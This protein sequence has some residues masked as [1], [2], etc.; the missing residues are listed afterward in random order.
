MTLKLGVNRLG[1]S[2][3]NDFQIEH[4]T[5]SSRHCEI[6]V[7]E[8]AILVRDCGSTNGTYVC[9]ERVTE[10]RLAAG[11]EFSVGDVEIFV[12]TTDVTI[13]VPKIEVT[14]PAPPVVLRDGSLECPRHPDAQ[15]THQCT[16]C[17][18]V[19]CEACVHRLR[20]RGGK[21]LELCPICS[22]RCEPIGPRKK[23]KKSLIGF[24]RKTV[25]M[26]LNRNSKEP[27]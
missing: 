26:K 18:E 13:S 15:V 27:D 22:S 12:E 6:S 7:E 20:R 9:G 16:R 5:I 1:R 2:P 10:A 23:K 17:K 14:L 11:Q 19:M 3:G 25:K 4:A 8:G 24:F 21:L